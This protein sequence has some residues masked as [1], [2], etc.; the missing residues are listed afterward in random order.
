MVLDGWVKE[1]VLFNFGI[2]F[3]K[4][5]CA[6]EK[7]LYTVKSS[8][9][10]SIFITLIIT[11]FA[12]VLLQS[13]AVCSNGQQDRQ[14]LVEQLVARWMQIGSEQYERHYFKAAEQSFLMAKDY[15][16]YL[17]SAQREQLNGLL[18]KAHAA[19]AEVDRLSAEITQAKQLLAEGRLAEAR[20]LFEGV[21]NSQYLTDET[22]QIVEQGLAA[23]SDDGA[24]RQAEISQLYNRSVDYYNAGDLEKARAG[25]LEVSKSDLMIAPVG[26]RA[27]DYLAKIDAALAEQIM[28]Q[29]GEAQP[30]AAEIEQELFGTADQAAMQAGIPAAVEEPMAPQPVISVVTPKPVIEAPQTTGQDGGYIEVIQRRQNI[31]RSHTE[32]VVND[33]LAKARGYQAENQFDQAVKSVEYAQNTVNRNRLHLGEEQF[34]R[35]SDELQ[36][37][38]DEISS[39]QSGYKTQVAEAARIQAEQSQMGIRDQMERDRRNRVKELMENTLAYQKQ[40]RYKEALGQLQSLIAIDPLNQQALIMKDTLEDT[41]SFED[42][43]RVLKERQRERANMLF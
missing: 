5:D 6:L 28:Q 3:S 36:R 33:A 16:E 38:R 39:A 17:S 34:G 22:Q 27:E 21:R 9:R 37:M 35:Y 32:A 19:A 24:V 12:A 29:Q 31:L 13:V 15:E 42:Q 1:I 2:L 20:V 14:K 8:G 23:T 26:T 11:L 4:E 43:L 30:G 18:E 41:I 10:N 25:F 40:Q 7:L